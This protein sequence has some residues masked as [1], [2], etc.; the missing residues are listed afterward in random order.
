M[1]LIFSYSSRA[2]RQTASEIAAQL[3]T[4]AEEQGWI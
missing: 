2:A 1:W 3:K 4:G